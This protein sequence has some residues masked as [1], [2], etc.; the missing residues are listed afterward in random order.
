MNVLRPFLFGKLPA[1]GDFVVR[2]L[3]ALQRDAWDRRCTLALEAAQSRLGTDY[4][5]KLEATPM[6]GFVLQP[7]E[8]G[9]IWQAGCVAPSCDRSGRPFLFVLGVFQPDSFAY[10]AERLTA[11]LT[12]LLHDAIAQ[13]QAPDTVFEAA[14]LSLRA[15]GQDDA[16]GA[17]INIVVMRDWCQDWIGAPTP[18]KELRR[19]E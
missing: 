5:S 10:P 3:D 15:A 2:G 7:A 14:T 9:G 1:A 11:R 17:A 12:P 18:S 6:R 16:P 4:R 8:P 19:D 13:R